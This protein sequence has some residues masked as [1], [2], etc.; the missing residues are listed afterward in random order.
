MSSSYGPGTELGTAVT[1]GGLV[2]TSEQEEGRQV[3][4]TTVPCDRAVTGQ[5]P[6]AGPTEGQIT[7]T[8]GGLTAEGSL[9]IVMFERQGKPASILIL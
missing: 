9:G 5:V 2:P 6:G 1:R 7:S 8:A 3:R 4:I